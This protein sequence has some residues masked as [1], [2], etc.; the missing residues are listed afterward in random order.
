MLGSGHDE[1]STEAIPGAVVVF[2][3][4]LPGEN[5]AVAAVCPFRKAF[6][7]CSAYSLS[8]SSAHNSLR[9]ACPS[10][11]GVLEVVSGCLK[12]DFLNS[13]DIKSL[14]CMPDV[15]IVLHRHPPSVTRSSHSVGTLQRHFGADATTA[16]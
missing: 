2:G 4:Y 16:W 12:I 7:K 9:C 3:A 5:S 8:L 6:S 10:C 1:S 15:E 13:F 11:L 14:A